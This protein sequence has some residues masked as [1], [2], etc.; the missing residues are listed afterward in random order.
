MVPGGAD[1]IGRS[2]P[3]LT[4][5]CVVRMTPRLDYITWEDVLKKGGQKKSRIL[6]NKTVHSC[7]ILLFNK[8]I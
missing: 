8:T 3:N 7:I 6:K 2:F 5:T 4:Y 1:G